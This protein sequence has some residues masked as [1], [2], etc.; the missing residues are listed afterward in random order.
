MQGDAGIRGI[1]LPLPSLDR[2]EE[3]GQPGH[4]AG[5]PD[6]VQRGDDADDD[7]PIA[8]LV[9]AEE[10]EIRDRYRACESELHAERYRRDPRYEGSG[11]AQAAASGGR[12]NGRLGP[13]Q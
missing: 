10:A 5:G 4:E 9:D 11:H 13:R 3:R 2:A 12:L 6:R 1:R 7:R 8:T